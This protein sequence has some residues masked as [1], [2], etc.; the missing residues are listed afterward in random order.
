MGNVRVLC[1]KKDCVY[2]IFVKKEGLA[3]Q[4]QCGNDE[5]EIGGEEESPQCFSYE[6]KGKVWSA[7]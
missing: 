7:V 2:Y 4:N 3:Y 1:D 5:I 6:G